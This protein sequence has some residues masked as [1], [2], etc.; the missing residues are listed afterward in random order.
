[1]SGTARDFLPIDGGPSS[2][3]ETSMSLIG[4]GPVGEEYKQRLAG[5][6]T[7]VENYL[8][9]KDISL[10]TMFRV[11]D[12]DSSGAMEFA[13]FKSKVKGLH[14]GLDDEEVIAIFK[15][16]DMNSSGSVTYAELVE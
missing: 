16:L 10:G 15:S 11:M 5:A 7:K 4:V 1:M 3:H 12:T 14:M 8:K 13:E 6:R 2:I 9:S